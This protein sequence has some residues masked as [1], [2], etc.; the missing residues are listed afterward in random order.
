[1]VLLHSTYHMAPESETINPNI[2]FVIILKNFLL[3]FSGIIFHIIFKLVEKVHLTT[4]KD[5][6]EKVELKGKIS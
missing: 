6:G 2:Y 5:S 3:I 4:L 1:M